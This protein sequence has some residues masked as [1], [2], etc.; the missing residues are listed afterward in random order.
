MVIA[1]PHGGDTK[2]WRRFSSSLA[3]PRGL[4]QMGW[5]GVGGQPSK[6]LPWRGS[7]QGQACVPPSQQEDR[8]LTTPLPETRDNTTP[9]KV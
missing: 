1:D 7:A 4:L 9:P 3:V 2:C 6:P 5:V 8:R